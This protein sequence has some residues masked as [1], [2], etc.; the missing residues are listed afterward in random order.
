[1]QL[2]CMPQWPSL[3]KAET[4]NDVA[5]VWIS[6]KESVAGALFP[7]VQCLQY[8]DSSKSCVFATALVGESLIDF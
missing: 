1:M 2:K 6:E 3:I 4:F 8:F 5:W 7:C